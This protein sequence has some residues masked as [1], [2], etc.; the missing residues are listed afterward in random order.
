M[1]T[2]VDPLDE[3]FVMIDPDDEVM[4]IDERGV[5]WKTLHTYKSVGQH[6]DTFN[7]F[8]YQN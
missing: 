6:K 7:A 4:M 3:N 5:K 2:L 8:T 1:R